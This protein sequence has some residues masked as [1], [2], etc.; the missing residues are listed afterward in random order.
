[1]VIVAPAT[2]S[3]T[4]SDQFD[5]L[6]SARARLGWL[7]WP[8]LLVY[9]TGGLAWAQVT[10]GGVVQ[11]AGFGTTSTSVSAVQ[12][13]RWGWAAGLG[14]ETRIGHGNWLGRLEYLHYDFGTSLSSTTVSAGTATVANEG[15]LTTDVVRV[16][17]SYQLN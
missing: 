13:W 6:G 3:E 2:E 16:G 14:A 15:R 10:Q 11:T 9:G 7:A 17:L 12:S 5:L 1:L 8:N 4:V